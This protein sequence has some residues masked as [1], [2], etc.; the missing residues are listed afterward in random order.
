MKNTID[1]N[2]WQR[3]LRTQRWRTAHRLALLYNDK[4]VMSNQERN[5]IKEKTTIKFQK[6]IV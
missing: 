4:P 5:R 1:F 3:F 6:Q 2:K